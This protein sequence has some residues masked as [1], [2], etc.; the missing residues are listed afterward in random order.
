MFVLLLVVGSQQPIVGSRI[1]VF[2][3][4]FVDQLLALRAQGSRRRKFL[5]ASLLQQD[6]LNIGRVVRLVLVGPRDGRYHLS[7]TV[8]PHQVQQAAQMMSCFDGATLQLQVKF[9]CHFSQGIECFFQMAAASAPA[10][11]ECL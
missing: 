11:L 6:G 9:A 10:S 3:I 5:P 1:G 8:Q 7:P 4:D 2:E